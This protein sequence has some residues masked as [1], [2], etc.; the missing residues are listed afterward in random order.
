MKNCSQNQRIYANSREEADKKGGHY[1]VN[2]NPLSVMVWIGMTEFGIISYFKLKKGFIF[3]FFD[4]LRSKTSSFFTNIKQSHEILT[5]SNQLFSF[6]SA[7]NYK[8]QF[9]VEKINIVFDSRLKRWRCV[10]N[11]TQ[12]PIV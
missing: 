10:S 4:Y 2:K 7:D 1:G 9:K 12:N 11:F 5:Y 3:N 6:T 8:V